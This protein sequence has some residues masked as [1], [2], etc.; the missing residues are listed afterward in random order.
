[1]ENSQNI[2]S[3][4]KNSHLVKKV[5]KNN[6]TKSNN[7]KLDP[8][9]VKLLSQLKEKANKK[10]FGRKIR[11]SEIIAIALKL[12]SS[13]HIKELQ[14]TS[15]THKDRL[16]LAH[17]DFQRTNGKISLDAFIGKLLSSG[18]TASTEA[19]RS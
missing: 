12:V 11:D 13:E 7:K 5:A 1:M 2:D 19:R 16:A 14:E 17:E 18:A 4:S 3:S 15:Y 10:T 9:S 6:A 8:E